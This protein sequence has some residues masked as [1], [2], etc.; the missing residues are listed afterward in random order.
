MLHIIPYNTRIFSV[1][2]W[3]MKSSLTSSIFDTNF[4]FLL[5][6]SFGKLLYDNI[7]FRIYQQAEADILRNDGGKYRIK[8]GQSFEKGTQKNKKYRRNKKILR[9]SWRSIG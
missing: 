8:T 9:R 3:A 2:I 7:S 5:L 4:S 1:I 6:Y